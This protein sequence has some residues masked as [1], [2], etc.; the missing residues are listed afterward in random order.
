PDCD[1]RVIDIS[2]DGINNDGFGPDL[3]YRHFPLD[4]ITVNGL[5]IL[6]HDIEVLDY[7]QR[8]VMRGPRAFTE[9]AQ[10]FEDFQAAMARK[11]YREINDIVL[12]ALS[13]APNILPQ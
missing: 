4:G 10:G 13:P 11:L 1:R 12:G 8:Q 9:V 2:G 7:Y 3:A 6:G 5:V